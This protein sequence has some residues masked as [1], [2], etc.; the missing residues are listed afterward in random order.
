MIFEDLGVNPE[1]LL[2][3]DYVLNPVCYKLSN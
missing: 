3:K 1:A 2:A